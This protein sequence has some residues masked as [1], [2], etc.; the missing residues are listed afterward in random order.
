[1]PVSRHLSSDFLHYP[2]LLDEHGFGAEIIRLMIPAPEVHEA[3]QQQASQF[4]VLVD[5]EFGG[6]PSHRLERDE[7]VAELLL[8]SFG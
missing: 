2:F 5:T 1:M 3:V 6:V 7:D 4:V 8:F